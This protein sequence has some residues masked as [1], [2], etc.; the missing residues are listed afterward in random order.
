MKSLN[1]IVEQILLAEVSNLKSIINPGAFEYVFGKKF[2]PKMQKQLDK[3]IWKFIEGQKAIDVEKVTYGKDSIIIE[4]MS[5]KPMPTQKQVTMFG[6]GLKRTVTHELLSWSWAPNIFEIKDLPGSVKIFLDSL[7]IKTGL[8]KGNKIP[9]E[10]NDFMIRRFD[11]MD[12]ATYD[13][14]TNSI[15]IVPRGMAGDIHPSDIASFIDALKNKIVGS[16]V[17]D[18]MSKNITR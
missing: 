2:S 9:K 8:F 11:E 13:K 1:T 12:Y 16:Q 5:D 10:L 17:G 14:K 3:P 6:K 15:D 4:P 18:L 7:K